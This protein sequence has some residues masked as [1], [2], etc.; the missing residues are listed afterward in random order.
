MIKFDINI[1]MNYGLEQPT[2]GQINVSH[3]QAEITRNWAG[4]KYRLISEYL[5]SCGG[6]LDIITF[7][8]NFHSA[9]RELIILNNPE[10]NIYVE[11]MPIEL[12]R[13]DT[14]RYDLITAFHTI[15]LN[16]RSW[17][18]G[19]ADRLNEG[20]R[21]I[22][23]GD[24]GDKSKFNMTQKNKAINVYTGFSEVKFTY[25]TSASAQKTLEDQGLERIHYTSSSRKYM[26]VYQKT[27][28]ID[29]QIENVI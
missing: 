21:L 22:L 10:R 18:N 16:N 20:G 27:N 15:Y 3:R 23:T 11:T 29:H 5:G 24:V 4:N 19:I 2:C 12:L 25:R 17:L 8:P 14:D 7:D 26:I 9:F 6:L 1:T 13:K 28:T